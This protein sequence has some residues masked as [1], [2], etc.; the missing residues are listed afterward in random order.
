[1]NPGGSNMHPKKE[2]V[3]QKYAI[4]EGLTKDQ[5]Q[6]IIDSMSDDN[7]D[8]FIPYSASAREEDAETGKENAFGVFG[9][10]LEKTIKDKTNESMVDAFNMNILKE[11]QHKINPGSSKIVNPFNIITEIRY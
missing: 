4:K 3:I 8:R 6:M 1:M 11:V 2:L 5:L 10:M 7:E 9:F